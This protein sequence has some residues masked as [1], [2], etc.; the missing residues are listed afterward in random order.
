MR[1]LLTEYRL[2]FDKNGV[3]NSEGR[4]LLEEMLRFL[5]YEHPEYKPLA[6]KT[7]KEPTLSNVIKLAE[8][9]MSLEEV[10]ELLSQNF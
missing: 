7:R 3:L 5:I 9:F 1:K 10:E 2:Y 6:S 4:K 8:V